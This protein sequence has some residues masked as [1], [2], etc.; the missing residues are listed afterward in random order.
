MEG[1]DSRKEK[2][3]EAQETSEKEKTC[4][5]EKKAGKAGKKTGKE[6]GKEKKSSHRT[7]ETACGL[8]SGLVIV[9]SQ[10]YADAYPCAFFQSAFYGHPIFFPVSKADPL[11]YVIDAKA[12]F[13]VP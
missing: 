2:T 1:T 4:K 8:K 13:G 10:G 5:P 11:V 9:W 7:Q 6:T 3:E 12:C